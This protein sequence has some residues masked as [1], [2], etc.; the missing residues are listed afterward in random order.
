ME[1][2]LANYE[3]VVFPNPSSDN[4]NLTL[5]STKQENIDLILTDI[6][7]RLVHQSTVSLYGKTTVN[8]PAEQLSRGLYL[9]HLKTNSGV[10]V[11]KILRD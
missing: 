11:V 2:I 10:G 9:L 8:I 5:N 1:D 3:A 4:F 7:G 6:E